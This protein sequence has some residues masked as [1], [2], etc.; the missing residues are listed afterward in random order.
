MEET[1]CREKEAR[2]LISLIDQTRNLESMVEEAD[3]LEKAVDKATVEMANS[4]NQWVMAKGTE[5]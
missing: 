1:Q 3:S 5:K 4:K 2:D